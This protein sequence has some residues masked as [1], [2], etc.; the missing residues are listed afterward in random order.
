M[1][2]K[3]NSPFALYIFMSASFYI[4]TTMGAV[5]AVMAAYVA[6]LF[7]T[8]NVGG[9]FGKILLGVPFGALCL[10]FVYMKIKTI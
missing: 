6:D 8:K 2:A 9:I 1:T 4:A 5:P 3:Y 10:P 7:G